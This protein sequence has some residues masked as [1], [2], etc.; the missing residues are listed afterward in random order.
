MRATYFVLVFQQ[1]QNI[2]RIFRTSITHLSTPMAY[3]AVHAKA[4]DL[5]LFIHSL[6][7]LPLWWF[8]VCSVLFCAVLCVLSNACNR[9]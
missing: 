3:A 4:V 2:V 6:L 9:L 8:C 7:F 5:L 1:Q